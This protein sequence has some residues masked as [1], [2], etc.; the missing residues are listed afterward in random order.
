MINKEKFAFFN[1]ITL[2]VIG[3]L[4]LMLLIKVVY[5]GFHTDSSGSVVNPVAFYVLSA[6]SQTGNIKM[7]ELKPDDQDYE[8]DF[9]VSNFKD[10][11]VSDVDMEYDLEIITTTNLPVSYKLYL[12]SQ[13]NIITSQETFQDNDS[14]YFTRYKTPKET[15]SKNVQKTYTYK[16]IV[17]FPSTY[18]SDVYQDLID[19]VQVK[20][21]SRQVE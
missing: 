19:S 6:G 17:N 4:L 20:I 14:M 8:Y 1:R 9:T 2:L 11:K 16:L 10:S 5:G 3:I 18:S 21:T 15:F 13:D 12:E 7:F